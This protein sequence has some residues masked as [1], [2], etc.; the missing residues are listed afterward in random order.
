MTGI[1]RFDAKSHTYTVGG[2]RVLSITQLLTVSGEVNE[3]FFTDEGSARGTAVHKLTANFDMGAID[4]ATGGGVYRPYLLA[5]ADA[6][7]LIPHRWTA[8]EEPFVHRGY[9]FAGTPDRVGIVRGAA[10]VFEIKSGGFSKSHQ[11]QT[12]LQAILV[13]DRLQLPPEMIQRYVLYVTPK[14]RGKVEIND[15]ASDFSKARS[16][17]QRF[18][19]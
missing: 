5:Y 12:A 16:I 9:R 11:V 1:F 4:L 8:I 10:S 6:L 17:L 19:A 2:K 3:E 7:A 18:C 14:G 13:S 15:K